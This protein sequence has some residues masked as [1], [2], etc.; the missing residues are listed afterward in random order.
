MNK[1]VA[2]IIQARSTSTRLPNKVLKK[3]NGKY[4]LQILFERIL[5]CNSIDK[6]ILATTTNKAD[7]VLVE[8]ANQFNFFTVR[9]EEEDVLSRFAKAVDNLDCDI[10]IRLT[11]DCPLLDPDLINKSI[12]SFLKQ[13]VD[14]LSNCY[15]PTFPDGLDVE[16]FTKESLLLANEKAKKSYQREHVTPWIRESGLFKVGV[17][18][19]PRDLSTSRWTVDE[20]EDLIVIESIIKEFKNQ[21]FFSWEKVVELQDKKPELFEINS[22]FKRNEGSK[23]SKGQKLW[24]R[25]K[26]VI[27]GGNM[28]LSKRPELYLPGKWPTYFSSAKGCHI[29]DLEGNEYVDMSIMG[30]G[31]NLLGYGHEEVDNEVRKV[32][33]Q[34]NMS[35]LNCPEEVLL[36][37]KLIDIHKWAHKVRFARSGGEANAIAIRIA[38]SYSGK[39]KIAICGYHGWHDW[40]LATNLQ[41]KSSLDNHLLPG[42]EVAGVPKNLKGTVKPF[43]MNDLEAFKRIVYENDLAAVKMEVE[44]NVTPAE[45]FL[46]EIREICT[47]N[48][49]VLIFDECTSGFRETFGGIHLK[50]GV[51][52]D[53]AMFGK[54]LGNGYA[55]TA[56]IGKDQI[57]DA[58][59]KT[60]IS[61]TFWTERIGPT[62]A[63][64]TLEI[65]ERE[66]SWDIVTRKGNNLKNL[67]QKYADMYG[68][69]IKH[70]GIPALA[71]FTFETNKFLEYKTF[72]AQEMLKSGY[73]ASTSCYSSTA[74]SE[75]DFENYSN[76]VEKIFQQISKFEDGEK[77][78]DK[79][80]SPICHSGFKRLN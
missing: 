2:A 75:D 65:M 64:K 51:N 12:S 5:R 47:Q 61:S 22:K 56:V 23:I 8:L 67:W 19:N 40:Y 18:K 11:G 41:D 14:Y 46:E 30:I 25:A 15:P 74:H 16:I 80:E 63:L 77:V 7:D 68:L 36:A 4:L 35:T 73:L 37:E 1:K 53:M 43:L 10:L 26:K 38:R 52:P 13:K 76:L 78:E 62:A 72:F 59:Q 9:G 39:D 60:F 33:A 45:G 28:L 42:L 24:E 50:Y 57:M 71:G 49:I 29:W 79:L 17:L 20:P 66:K 70:N 32:I 55:I 44:R 6:F 48:N 27:P 69:K 58:A 21:I 3:I 54:A 34:G 31:T